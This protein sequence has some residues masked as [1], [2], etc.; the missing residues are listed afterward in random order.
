MIDYSLYISMDDDYRDDDSYFQVEVENGLLMGESRVDG[1]PVYRDEWR[2]LIIRNKPYLYK[3]DATDKNKL[4]DLILDNDPN[5]TFW[6][7]LVH[8]ENITYGYFGQ[9]DCRINE[10]KTL[11]TINPAVIDQY[12]DF[13]ENYD[14]DIDV[15]GETN[16]IKNG[17]FKVW[18]NG[19]PDGWTQGFEYSIDKDTLL[20]QSCLVLEHGLTT[21]AS[22]YQPVLNLQNNRAVSVN[23]NFALVGINPARSNLVYS[24][25]LI[26]TNTYQLQS[27]GSWVESETTNK[28]EYKT[29]AL[30]IPKASI[31]SFGSYE[32]I[33]QNTPMAGSLWIRFYNDSN[34]D[35]FVYITNVAVYSSNI[36]Y[37]SVK[38]NLLGESLVEKPQYEIPKETGGYLMKWFIANPKDSEVKPLADYFN[39]DGSPDMTLLGTW[40]HGPH[41]E[42]GGAELQYPDYVERFANT[43]SNPF[44]KAELSELTIYKGTRWRNSFLEA[45]RR[46]IKGVAKFAREE[47]YKTDEYNGDDLLPPQDD[48][49]WY[50]TDNVISGKRLWVRT[51]YNGAYSEWEIGTLD[52]TGGRINDF[53][54]IEKL[55][56]RKVYPVGDNSK[57]INISVSF[58]DTCRK[59]YRSTHN[60]R[61][62]KEVYSAFF[63]NDSPYLDDV[64]I[65]TGENYHTREDNV[66]NNIAVLHTAILKEES[67]TNPDDDKL[68]VSF[69]DFFEDLKVKFPNL[70][71]FI[72]DD[73]NLHIEHVKFIDIVKNYLNILVDEFE[74]V[75]DYESYE[76][77]PN[78]LFETFEYKE[79]NSGYRDFKESK[80]IFDK[81]VSNK[82]TKDL[83]KEII[84]KYISTDIQ[85][86]IENPDSLDNGMILVAYEVVNEENIVKYGNG[87]ITG[88]LVPNGDLSI[89]TLLRKYAN[90]EGAWTYGHIND[91]LV[92]FPYTTKCKKGD[93]FVLK[94]I[95][96]DVFFLTALGI[97]TTNTKEYDYE[98]DLTRVTPIYR[99]FDQFLVM[100]KDDLIEL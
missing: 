39:E 44:Y 85:F 91:E 45:W 32:L 12:T 34:F 1:M 35:D 66:L 89:S 87:Q 98:N 67:G 24:A 4:Y 16:L 13:I 23:F 43:E 76:F 40:T 84:A 7:K 11:I 70:I 90:Y 57:T 56:S 99:H 73:L 59:I 95:Q 94:G 5:V 18:T 93:V 6:I 29:N 51:P 78:E 74:Y 60:S 72:D 30:P 80:I 9:V 49:G 86:A 64:I 26:G 77:D 15:F 38:I 53:D 27:D 46:H 52:T 68:E 42:D 81:I 37:V 92:N 31:E 41:E 25:S 100:G 62:D 69:K 8:G 22:V 48:V 71:W 88:T 3:D 14:T 50:A 65:T 97:A 47:F 61:L 54:W 10:N 63:W 17:D 58:R 20:D 55:T 33:T 36:E 96:D 82:R 19:N 21:G 75:G 83:K 79:I 2:E 28:I